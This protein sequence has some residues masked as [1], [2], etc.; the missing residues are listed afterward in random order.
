MYDAHNMA[1]YI[2][3]V[4]ELRVY[5]ATLRQQHA[6]TEFCFQ[7]LHSPSFTMII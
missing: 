4:A 3:I 5:P 7:E 1:V 2:A 6:E